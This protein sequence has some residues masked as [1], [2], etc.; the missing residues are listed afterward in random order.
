MVTQLFFKTQ[1]GRTLKIRFTQQFNDPENDEQVDLVTTQDSVE[2]KP[3]TYSEVDP[4]PRKDAIPLSHFANLRS[5]RN[6]TDGV[7]ESEE[8]ELKPI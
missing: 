8:N 6:T 7:S 5:R 2:G 1:L 3:A 4:P